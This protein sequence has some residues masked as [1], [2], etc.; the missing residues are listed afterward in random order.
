MNVAVSRSFGNS[1]RYPMTRG[2]LISRAS[3]SGRTALTWMV[4]R[5][6]TGTTT[7][8]FAAKSNGMPSTSA[9]STLKSPSSF[10]SYDWRRSARPMTCSQ[11]SCVPKA[12]TPSTW[13]TVLASHPSVSMETETTQRMSLP[14]RPSFPTVFMTSRRTSTSSISSACT[15]W[16]LRSTISRRNCS[17]S[18]AA[19]FRKLSSKGSPDSSCSLSIRSVR[20]RG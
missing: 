10:R 7:T 17:S 18:A 12:R 16:P 8:G 11:R 15:C 13:V 5:G 19:A 1:T 2:K 4:C 14:R 9:Y 6:G 20:G 3:R